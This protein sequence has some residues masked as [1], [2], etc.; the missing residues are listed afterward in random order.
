MGLELP[1]SG[2]ERSL[3]SED[4]VGSFKRLTDAERWTPDGAKG[5][6][7]GHTVADD[8]LTAAIQKTRSLPSGSE[9]VAAMKIA[10]NFVDEDS[11]VVAPV[12]KP[13]YIAYRADLVKVR[14][15]A[16]EGNFRT[17]KYQKLFSRKH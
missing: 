5:W 13:D 8:R 7:D 12:R 16:N 3:T 15:G 6:A 1:P 10:R 9:G 14:F 2:F 4:V 17:F 11:N